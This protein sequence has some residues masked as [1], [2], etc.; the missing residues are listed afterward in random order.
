[1]FNVPAQYGWLNSL[2]Q[3]PLMTVKALELLGTIETPGAGN[4]PTIMEWANELG[5]AHVYTADAIPWCGLFMAVVTK[6]ADKVL[7]PAPLWALSWAKFGTDEGQPRLG[8]VLTFTRDGGGHVTQYIGEDSEAYHC[9]GGNQHD[10]V[11]FTRI[12]KK[13]LYRVRRPIYTNMPATAQPHVLTA[14]GVLSS[15][16]A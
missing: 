5:L 1:M 3:L 8:D 7:P 13:R 15:N 12:E 9:L 11:C 14:S 2:G 10:C 16:E 4:S 6:R